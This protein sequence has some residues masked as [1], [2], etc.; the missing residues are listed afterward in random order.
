M[1]TRLSKGGK[2][3]EV[4]VAKREVGVVKRGRRGSKVRE[5][6]EPGYRMRQEDDLSLRPQCLAG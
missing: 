3:R 6:T 1:S 2:N 4:G 5:G